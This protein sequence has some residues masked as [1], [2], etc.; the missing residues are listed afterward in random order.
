MIIFK[1]IWIN[2]EKMYR[3]KK[4]RWIKIL[5]ILIIPSFKVSLVNV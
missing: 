4:K 1:T 3:F 2:Y 5:A